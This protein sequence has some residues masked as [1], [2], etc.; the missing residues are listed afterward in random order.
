MNESKKLVV[1][2]GVRTPFCKMG[3]DLAAVS[4]V[5]LAAGAMRSMMADAGIR[6][7]VVD[8]VILGCVCQ[9]FDAANIA[10]VVALRAGVPMD[11]P[12]VTVQRNCASGMESVISAAV[13]M[14][15]CCGDVFLVG[16]VESMSTVPLLFRAQAAKKFAA[17]A[18]ERGALGKLKRMAAF[19]P[20]DFAPVIGLQLG[21][22]DPV[23][24]LGMGQTAEL[25]AREY[26]ISR[27]AQD[28]FANQSHHKAAAG[29]EQFAAEIAPIYTAKGKAVT[30]DNGVRSDSSVEGLGRLRP[31]FDR[32]FG[33]VTAGNSSQISDGAAVML[34]ASEE[35]ARS[36][37]WPVLGRV[38]A[39]A[40][41]GCDPA[42]M[43]LGPVHAIR[44][45]AKETG[46]K[47]DACDV[48]EINEAFAVQ[49]LAVLKELENDGLAVRADQL[50]PNGGAIALGHP[51]GASG[52]RLL[53][54][55]LQTLRRGGGK[56]ALASLCVGGGQGVAVLM[57][58]EKGGA[59]E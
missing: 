14:Q 3:S 37:G 57:S 33:S 8:E 52:A 55:S 34:V 24:G 16:G 46:V 42:R 20:S 40:V 41:T 54:T 49:V 1:V 29:A 11:R 43:G 28:E 17:L 47:P 7:D 58:A 2:A 44:K 21:L 12:A 27:E 36:E 53:L 10:R 22:T 26:G 56:R 6:M 15:A 38:D 51:V 13:R 5:D 9:P 32:S 59:N 50:N 4:A 39:F 35:R 31:V 25:L 18:R 48:V 30:T 23:S 45:I 19:R